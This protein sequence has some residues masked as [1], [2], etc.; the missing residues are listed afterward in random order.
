MVEKALIWTKNKRNESRKRRIKFLRV[1]SLFR[2][3]LQA[4]IDIPCLED[5]DRRSNPRMVN[6]RFDG[7][8]PIAPVNAPAE[9][10]A[11]RGHD[12]GRVEAEK[13]WRLLEIGYGRKCSPK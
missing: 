2:G 13:E 11:V 8:R 12:R 10:Y 4:V 6:T 9:E 5:S 1:S 7:V 3:H